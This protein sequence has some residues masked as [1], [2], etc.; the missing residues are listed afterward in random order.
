MEGNSQIWLFRQG[1]W[2]F[3]ATLR[4]MDG[5]GDRIR[6]AADE[7]GGLKRL[8]E[9]IETPRRSLGNWLT[10]TQPKPEN[11][12]RIADVTGVS[13]QWLMSGEGSKKE[14]TAKPISRP[15]Y[16][17]VHEHVDPD[18]DTLLRRFEGTE[19]RSAAPTLDIDLLQRLGDL[20]QSVFHE[21]KQTP[22]PRAITA[23]A[24][25]LYNELLQMVV[26]VHDEEVVEALLPV[27]RERLKKRLEEA[28]AEP[29]TGKRLA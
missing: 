15:L 2:P 7:V 13:L 16:E 29:G 9:L 23:E 11:L 5:L 27:I 18:V 8:A 22:P 17:T 1:E 6:E 10:G 20:A 21:C 19:P 26:D 14:R 25:R 24:G 4:F 3:L 12:Q 28:T